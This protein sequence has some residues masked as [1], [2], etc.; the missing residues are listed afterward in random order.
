MVKDD[1]QY[2]VDIFNVTDHNVHELVT[3]RHNA[4]RYKSM[5]LIV[6]CMYLFNCCH[7]A[8]IVIRD[9]AGI[10]YQKEWYL[11]ELK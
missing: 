5:S 7:S 3:S 11:L 6:M 9:D 4:N 8:N 1:A 10:F 2:A